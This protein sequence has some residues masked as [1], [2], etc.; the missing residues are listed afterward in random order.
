MLS[1][2]ATDANQ[3]LEFQPE[4]EFAIHTTLNTTIRWS[5][6]NYSDRGNTRRCKS[7]AHMNKIESQRSFCSERNS[8]GDDI[9]ARTSCCLKWEEPGG[10]SAYGS[11]CVCLSAYKCVFIR[12]CVSFSR[13][14]VFQQWKWS[15]P[16]GLY[17]SSPPS[18]LSMQSSFS[19]PGARCQ[20]A[21]GRCFI[22][23]TRDSGGTSQCRET[24]DTFRRGSDDVFMHKRWNIV[25]VYI[26][27]D[28]K[29]SL[30]DY[31]LSVL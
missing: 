5:H 27:K 25:Y 17:F 22:W 12:R 23:I 28:L 18:D 7:D 19:P 1:P 24:A 2:G 31:Y 30:F 15:S 4:P 6:L 13:P 21:Y 3:M 14:Q 10:S 9:N 16:S 8:A 26:F 20:K 29:S 11:V